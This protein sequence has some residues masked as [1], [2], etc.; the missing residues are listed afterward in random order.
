MGNIEVKLTAFGD[1]T[2]FFVNDEASLR[3]ML[4]IMS[5]YSKYSSLRANCEKCEAS[6]I[7]RSKTS[8]EKPVNCRWVSLVNGTIKILGIHF[9]YNK[10]LAQK[11]NF[12]KPVTSCKR[13]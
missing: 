13:T 9:S 5:L 1:D 8:N 7:G 12:T 2:T 3:R 6:W 4:K 10:K 11:G